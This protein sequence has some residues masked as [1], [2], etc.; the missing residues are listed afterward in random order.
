[1][2][3]WERETEIQTV[4]LKQKWLW[5]NAIKKESE[6]FWEANC[7]DRKD[8]L[9]KIVRERKKQR[10]W[11]FL[12]TSP[13]STLDHVL[14]FHFFFQ[15]R[16]KAT[17]AQH[18]ALCIFDMPCSIFNTLKF[19]PQQILSRKTCLS[20]YRSCTLA[21]LRVRVSVLIYLWGFSFLP[22]LKS[23]DTNFN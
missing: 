16:L 21:A 5:E 10:I 4:V 8:A 15:I 19:L 6:G 7:G 23:C 20:F 1:M 18:M 2:R 22:G 17:L 13:S 12:K 3:D 9:C 14:L 11:G